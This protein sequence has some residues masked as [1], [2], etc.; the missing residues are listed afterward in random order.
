AARAR[1]R[2]ARLRRR[3]FWKHARGSPRSAPGGAAARRGRPEGGSDGGYA[4]WKCS[5]R[6]SRA[7]LARLPLPAAFRPGRMPKNLTERS[8]DRVEVRIFGGV[9]DG[10]TDPVALDG[11]HGRAQALV[12][13]REQH[14]KPPR[15]TCSWGSV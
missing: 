11:G 7:A 5:L 3:A 2:P 6:T 14:G 12:I 15:A 10:K 1:R 4:A 9:V 8:R 13:E